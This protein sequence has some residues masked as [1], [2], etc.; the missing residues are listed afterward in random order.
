MNNRSNLNLLPSKIGLIAGG[1]Q[2]PILV[3]K[4][5]SKKG[6]KIYVTAIEGE[7]EKDIEEYVTKVKWINP[8]NLNE[9]FKFF[10]RNSITHIIMAGKVS[11]KLL[12]RKGLKFDN[13]AKLLFK[14]I[15]D[16]RDV[17]ILGALSEELENLGMKLID[18]RTF[19]EEYI[20]KKGSLTKI[21]LNEREW[22]DIRFG[23]NVAKRISA[24]DIGM[25]VIV[26]DLV[27][28]A[29]E[30]MEGTDETIKRG[31]RLGKE[32]VIVIKVARPGQDMRFDLPVVGK[33]TINIMIEVKAR[34]LVLE[35]EKTLFFDKDNAISLAEKNNISIISI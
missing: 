30:A 11:K 32:G 8:G 28:I 26:K 13:S 23:W 6:K 9:F 14:K 25:T 1:T 19:L 22:N 3:A 20:P 4:E 16:K 2:Y 15:K 12:F 18:S 35:A 7:A 29:V 33:N 31:G 34:V 17:S 10:K 24:L 27:I 5:A 21:P